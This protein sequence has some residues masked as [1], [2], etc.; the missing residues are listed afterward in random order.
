MDN[1]VHSLRRLQKTADV[2]DFVRYTEMLETLRILSG[3]GEVPQPYVNY[4]LRA[5]NMA[6]VVEAERREALSATGV[7]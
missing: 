7:V 6:D 3:C 2:A 1:L 4:V 5:I